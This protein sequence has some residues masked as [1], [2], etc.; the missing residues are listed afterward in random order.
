MSQYRPLSASGKEWVFRR[1]EPKV[2]EQ[3]RELILLLS[4]SAGA[5]IWRDYV[6][7]VALYPDLL[8]ENS[9]VKLNVS[10]VVNWESAW[11]SDSKHTLPDEIV[12]HCESWGDDTKVYFCCHAD[13]VLETTWGVFARNWKAFLFLDSDSILVGRKKK[14]ALQFLENGQTSLS[15]R[16]S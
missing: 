13:L 2:S 4:E 11:E 14:Q 15:Y 5:N 7:D 1:E 16:A 6:S 9:W 8:P 3:D 10:E 12:S